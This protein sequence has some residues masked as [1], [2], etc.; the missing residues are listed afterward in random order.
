MIR[1]SVSSVAASTRSAAV[2]ALGRGSF[3]LK[4]TQSSHRFRRVPFEEADIPRGMVSRS[5]AGLFKVMPRIVPKVC[6]EIVGT[7]RSASFHSAAPLWAAMAPAE[8]LA[9]LRALRRVG[10]MEQSP[11]SWWSVLSRGKHVLMQH[12]VYTEGKCMLSLG[13]IAG[14]CAMAIPMKAKAVQGKVFYVFGHPQWHLL[15]SNHQSW[16]VEGY[17]LCVEITIMAEAALWKV[18]EGCHHCGLAHH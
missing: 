1:E 13:C 14:S 8:D 7:K 10:R 4:Q 2:S 16:F 5:A 15:A 3:K 12:S 17:V 11:Q 9:L 18:G 6:A